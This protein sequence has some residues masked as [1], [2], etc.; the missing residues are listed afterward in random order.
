MAAITR[1]DREEIGARPALPTKELA[2][3]DLGTKGKAAR[4]LA[5]SLHLQ[6]L[7]AREWRARPPYTR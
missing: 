4:I 3:E 6:G 2:L 5:E 1:Q 7:P